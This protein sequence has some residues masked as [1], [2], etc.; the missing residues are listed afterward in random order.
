MATI[1][2]S[3]FQGSPEKTVVKMP[4]GTPITL[5]PLMELGPEHDEMLLGTITTL[6]AMKAEDGRMDMSEIS[7]I[8][9]V[10]NGLLLAA[11]PSKQAAERLA[12]LPLMARFQAFMGYIQDQD[13]GG[14]S[15][16]ES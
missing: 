13:L 3:D 5:K 1:D 4:T 11:A 10:V 2:V 12:K 14:L 16:S 9:P 6:G 15:P 7:A 8:M